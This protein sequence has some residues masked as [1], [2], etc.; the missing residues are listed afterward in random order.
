LDLSELS[1][2]F[3]VAAQFI[4]LQT[5]LTNR[6]R[7]LLQQFK[8]VD[9]FGDEFDDFCDTAAVIDLL[10]LVVTVDTS[11]AHL[12]GAM[13]RPVWILLP[14]NADWRWL[15]GREDS[16]WYPS[17]RLFRQDGSYRWAGVMSRVCAGLSELIDRSSP[18]MA[19][20]SID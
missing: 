12:A 10:D 16:P 7:G 4:S 6:E 2:L 14:F 8:V 5:G 20:P 15:I 9:Q 17:A 13:G 18:D 1:P 3:S 19:G 11:V